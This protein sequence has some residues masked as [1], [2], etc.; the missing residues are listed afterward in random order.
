MAVELQNSNFE[1][2]D[3]GEEEEEELPDSPESPLAEALP[4]DW[5]E[6]P[7]PASPDRVSVV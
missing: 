7:P 1:A 6:S 3:E 2:F 4:E 5:L